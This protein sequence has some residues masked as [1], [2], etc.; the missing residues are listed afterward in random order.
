LPGVAFA[1]PRICMGALDQPVVGEPRHGL[2]ER[3]FAGAQLR[4]QLGLRKRRDVPQLPLRGIVNDEFISACLKSLPDG[5]EFL[6]LESASQGVAEGAGL[7]RVA[8]ETDWVAGET[9]GELLEALEDAMGRP[10]AVGPHPPWLLDT[11]DVIAAV[12][13]DRDGVVRPGV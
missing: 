9:H 3:R 11:D 4:A 2:F 1:A 6:F 8:G 13:P 7:R 10:V 5:S 12:V